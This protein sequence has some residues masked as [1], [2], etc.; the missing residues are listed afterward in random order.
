MGIASPS[1]SC[2]PTRSS[3]GGSTFAYPASQINH[4]QPSSLAIATGLDDKSG[5]WVHR[6][7]IWVEERL[8]P[9]A[10]YNGRGYLWLI[11]VTEVVV[12]VASLSG[13][14]VVTVSADGSAGSF[15]C[16]FLLDFNSRLSVFTRR[17]PG[18]N[19]YK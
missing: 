14:V 4:R 6:M 16:I 18:T 11:S 10:K 7:R 2:L 5:S 15:K 9:K 13:I 19:V 8:E 17:V 3:G 1:V 12:V